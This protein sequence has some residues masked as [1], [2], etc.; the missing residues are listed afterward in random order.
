[1]RRSRLALLLALALI[2]PAGSHLIRP[3]VA[4][5]C[6]PTSIVASMDAYEGSASNAFY[7]AAEGKTGN[8]SILRGGHDCLSTRAEVSYQ[9]VKETADPVLDHNLPATETW[10]HLGAPSSP[11]DPNEISH[12]LVSFTAAVD[13]LVE[14][15]AEIATF[16]LLQAKAPNNPQASIRLIDPT[17][18]SV[19]IIDT[20]GATRFRLSHGA[21]S[22][23]EGTAAATIPVIRAG[24]ATTIETVEF[25]IA[26][27][28]TNPAAT[29]GEDYTVDA[30]SG[31]LSFA[32][33]DHVETIPVRLIN[34]KRSEPTESF[35]VSLTGDDIAAG[36]PTIATFS[37]LDNEESIPPTS[38]FHHPKHKTRYDYDSSKGWYLRE[39][40][41]FTSDRGGSGVVRT[42]MALR[43]KMQNGKCSWW[44]GS[45]FRRAPC[46]QK[47][48]LRMNGRFD[49]YKYRIKELKPTAGTK[50]KNYT[51][52]S[53]AIDGA[54]NV[55]DAFTKGRNA[56]TF[57]IAR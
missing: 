10:T 33:G 20:N 5:A 45:R 41:V 56:N 29:R 50:V 16:K 23:S 34:D 44:A 12:T 4:A 25:T 53:R 36:E 13:G 47:K 30:E 21:Y 54:G 9:A 52:F 40:H 11:S 24:P 17:Q 19:F 15:A 51:A 18:A 1:L 46:V 27:S 38:K 2:V 49:F 26:P 42:Q 31:E 8:V 28:E 39:I 48:W 32:P 55:Q 14:N 57:T 7:W 3:E 35:V 6:A 43:K 37:I 22:Q